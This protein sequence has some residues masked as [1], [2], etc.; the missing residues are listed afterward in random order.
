LRSTFGLYLLTVLFAGFISANGQGTDTTQTSVGLDSLSMAAGP[1]KPADDPVFS[2]LVTCDAEDSIKMSPVTNKAYLY[3][4]A[5]VEYDGTKLEAGFIEIDFSDN[6]VIATG[7]LDTTGKLTQLPVF[8]DKGKVYRTDTMRYNF[9]TKKAYIST[10]VTQEGEGYIHGEKVKMANENTFYIQGTAFTTCNAEHP[11]FQIRAKKAKV[12]VGDKIVT[13]PAFVEVADV[14]TP[15]FVPF[16]FFPTQ[17]EKASG[18]II[19]TWTSNKNRGFGLI[20]GGYFWAISPYYDL[21]LKTDIYTQGGWAASAGSRYKVKYKYN[22]NVFF[23]Y[24]RVKFGQPS[25]VDYGLPY[26]DSKDFQFNWTHNQDPKARPDLRFSS[27]V[28][29]AS[30]SYF[31]NN[32]TDLDNYLTNTLRSTINLTK[33][34]SGTPFV[35]NVTAAHTQN[36]KTE[37]VDVTLPKLTFTMTRINPFEKKNRVGKKKWYERIGV[38]YTG[39]A[40]ATLN[41]TIDGLSN[42]DYAINKESRLGVRHSVGVATNEKVL[43]YFV[44]TP[45]MSYNER[46]YPSR[47]EYR[48][49][50]STQTAVADTINEFSAVRDVS[51]SAGLSTNMYGQ[52]NFDGKVKALRHVL[53]PTVNFSYSPDY[54]DPFFGY[55]QTVQSDSTGGTSSLNRYNGYIY[56]SPGSGL[57]GVVSFNVKNTLEAKIG[58]NRD[59]T[60]VRKIKILDRFSFYTAYSLSVDQFNWAPLNVSATSTILGNNFTVNYSGTFDFYGVE[61]DGTR[62]NKTAWEVNNTLLRHTNSVFNLRWDL[63]GKARGSGSRRQDDS[64]GGEPLGNQSADQGGNP[65]GLEE[66]NY[67]YYNLDSYMD[68]NAP[69]AVGFGYSVNLRDY[70]STT[71]DRFVTD[72]IQTLDVTASFEPTPNWV[73][74]IQSGWDFVANDFSFTRVNLARDLHCWQLNVSW[75]PFGYQQSY[76]FGLGIKANLFKDVKYERNRNVGDFL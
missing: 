65:L 41:T 74:G 60:G 51:L 22:G 27:S 71:E 11:H 59:S 52:F 53:T 3:N 20:N 54:A 55:Y 63:K 67:N 6:S 35:L 61:S 50:D 68:F 4:Q 16:G 43:K 39:N 40:E 42:L 9:D 76:T 26:Q 37:K 34:W 31:Q 70:F 44:L 64:D 33:S 73:L 5:I 56:G 21:T 45:S 49:D 14:P 66:G 47:L 25:Y 18:F 58:S 24:N 8:T 13:G 72:V 1:V 62:V 19:P 36:N 17:E 7:V 75:V 2:D 28:N 12:I 57:N 29:L 69:W 30:Q 23:K 48:Y 38:N 15:V 10:I 32:N 46:W